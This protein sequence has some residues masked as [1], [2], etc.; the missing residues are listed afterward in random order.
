MDHI[1]KV[2]DG[3]PRATGSACEMVL[4]SE[5]IR[6]ENNSNFQL[7]ADDQPSSY[8]PGAHPALFGLDLKN[9]T[10]EEYLEQ[11]KSVSLFLFCF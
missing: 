8:Q 2:V 7:Y 6:F 9:M 10:Y 1:A 11:Y 4:A 5:L 3:I